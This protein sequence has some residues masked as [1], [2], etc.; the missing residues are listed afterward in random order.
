MEI[1]EDTLALLGLLGFSKHLLSTNYELGPKGTNKGKTKLPP[2]R[3]HLSGRELM[4]TFERMALK[5]RRNS[6]FGA[7]NLSVR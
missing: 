5:K 1:R 2:Q 6:V 7:A 4:H 3:S